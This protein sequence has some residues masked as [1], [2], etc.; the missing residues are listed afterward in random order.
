MRLLVAF[1]FCT[2]AFPQSKAE[3]ELRARLAAAQASLNEAEKEKAIMA[4]A[5][6]KASA[7]QVAGANKQVA[8]SQ[9]TAAAQVATSAQ[10]AAAT[11]AQAAQLA[12][13]AAAMVAAKVQEQIAETQRQ[14]SNSHMTLLITQLGAAIATLI[15]LLYKA[16]VDERQRRWDHEAMMIHV[17][18]VKTEAKAATAGVAE[19]KFSIADLERRFN[20]GNANLEGSK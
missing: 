4:A 13:T 18:E 15:G 5:L 3:V 12:V 17:G 10:I 7:G 11:N 1:L 6:V 8:E 16:W 9:S 2:S 20:A 19:N 14:V